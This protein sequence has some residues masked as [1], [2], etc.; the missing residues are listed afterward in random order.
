MSPVTVTGGR[1]FRRFERLV[2]EGGVP[3]RFAL[4]VQRHG[5]IN[6]HGEFVVYWMQAAR[7]VEANMALELA[8]RQADVLG[9]PLLI[10]ESLRPDYPSA[11]VRLHTFVLDGVRE[12]SAAARANGLRYAFFLPRTKTEARGKLYELLARAACLVTDEYPVWM[13]REHNVRICSRAPA[14]VILVDHNGVLPMRAM[15]GEQYAAKHFRDRAHRMF[16]EFWPVPLAVPRC[17]RAWDGELP[18]DPW[19]GDDAVA[20]ARS[21]EID[22]SVPPVGFSGTRVEGLGRLRTFIHERLA[23]YDAHRNRESFRTS[24][25]SPWIHF[26]VLGAQ[27]IANEVL[28]ADAPW[29]DKDAFLEEL[30]IRRE[31]AFNF[32]F[33]NSR[34]DSVDALPSWAAATLARHADDR[35]EPLYPAETLE[36]AETHDEVWNLSQRGLLVMGTVQTYLRMLWGKKILE[37]S[38]DAASAHRVMIDLHEKWALDGRDPNTYANVLWCLG[39]HD[40]PW[41]PERPIFG[42]IRYM[43]SASTMKKV[44][45]SAWRLKLQREEISANSRLHSS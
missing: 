29:E 17:R 40:R 26:G 30:V 21:C 36:R 42:S 39:K 1:S 28:R 24:E 31:L 7:R 3:D 12:R 19:S 20:A 10:Y 34:H 16:E 38:P 9:L 11:N 6:P 43:S 8:A 41:A 2:V 33:F 35:R 44:D 23:G 32:C 37:W 4:R 22:Q 5:A 27:E 25:L 14:Q 18:F 45:L 15:P 13:I